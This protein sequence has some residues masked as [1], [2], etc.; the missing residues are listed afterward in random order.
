ME[1]WVVRNLEVEYFSDEVPGGNALWKDEGYYRGETLVTVDLVSCVVEIRR[2]RD[3]EEK[4][5]KFS[6]GGDL[7]LKRLE[8]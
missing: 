4:S 8:L 7:G 1:D 5:V 6:G 3:F 2:F